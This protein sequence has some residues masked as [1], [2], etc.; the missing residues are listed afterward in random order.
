[1]VG[2]SAK[3]DPRT[4]DLRTC[5]VM[6]HS[7]VP[8]PGCTTTCGW[9]RSGPGRVEYC[10]TARPALMFPIVP[11]LG[12]TSPRSRTIG[13]GGSGVSDRDHEEAAVRRDIECAL[14][15]RLELLL[16]NSS[17]G[18]SCVARPG[19]TLTAI[20][21]EPLRS[22]SSPPFGDQ[23]GS[24]PPSRETRWG[25]P[26]AGTTAPTS[27]AVH[28][29]RRYTRPTCRPATPAPRFRQIASAAID[30]TC[31][32]S[33][34]TVP[35]PGAFQLCPVRRGRGRSPGTQVIGTSARRWSPVSRAQ[36]NCRQR[37]RRSDNWRGR[38]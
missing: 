18:D 32:R 10:L 31:G 37:Q 16:S 12:S 38:G 14:R 24:R 21:F 17:R 15:T 33:S 35:D 4:C 25:L 7:A 1:M 20:I 5:G 22:N 13:A 30:A 26:P 29:D 9:D 27:P 28:S 36:A 19:G 2:W 34:G 23:T 3:A 6:A 11:H 8:P